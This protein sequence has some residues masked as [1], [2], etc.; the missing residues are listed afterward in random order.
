M[1]IEDKI[2]HINKTIN[3]IS[4]EEEKLQEF[5]FPNELEEY[6]EPH[7]QEIKGDGLNKMSPADYK[8]LIFYR[9]LSDGFS[10][11]LAE[12][13]SELQ[14]KRERGGGQSKEESEHER[15]LRFYQS[16][17]IDTNKGFTIIDANDWYSLQVQVDN[18]QKLSSKDSERFLF[19]QLVADEEKEYSK[20]EAI[21]LA[22]LET[23]NSYGALSE[24]EKEE[25]IQLR[26]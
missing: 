5:L 25:L 7:I 10:R 8:K 11:E 15:F 2:N 16:L 24:Q 23:M 22:K 4:E 18:G 21:R 1:S 13:I 6:N 17:V 26:R 20:E 3:K 14:T 12:E 19:Y 9:Y